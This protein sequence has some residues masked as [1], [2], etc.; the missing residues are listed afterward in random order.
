MG[1]SYGLKASSSL[2]GLLYVV[3]TSDPYGA[4]PFC[5]PEFWS[6]KAV[7]S[8]CKPGSGCRPC[9]RAQICPTAQLSLCWN[10]RWQQQPLL[11]TPGP[12]HRRAEPSGSEAVIRAVAA[13]RCTS[14]LSQRL[15]EVY[16]G[17]AERW[18]RFPAL[19][20]QLPSAKDHIRSE[21]VWVE[22]TVG[23]PKV[24]LVTLLKE[25]DD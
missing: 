3:Q 6:T 8:G 19:F 18:I 12:S 11:K 5:R 13:R 1:T 23:I 9:E 15:Y 10:F 21:S 22:N 25:G 4:I 24:H 16:D 7:K 17:H 20:L 14:T 2:K